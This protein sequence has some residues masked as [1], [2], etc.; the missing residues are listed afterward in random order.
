M[1]FDYLPEDFFLVILSILLIVTVIELIK[2]A[3]RNDR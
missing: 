1:S 3:F 2:K